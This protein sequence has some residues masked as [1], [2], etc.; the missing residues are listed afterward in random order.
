MPP[1]KPPETLFDKV[2]KFKEIITGM[3]A[4]ISALASGY[5]YVTTKFAL[6]EYVDYN[7]CYLDK[8]IQINDYTMKV[9]TL[10]AELDH[11][12]TSV[13]DWEQ[14]YNNQAVPVTEVIV[15]R[16]LNDEVAKLKSDI[17]SYQTKLSS[18]EARD[19]VK[20]L[21]HASD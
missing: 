20:E 3:V 16:K 18:Q 12:Y 2:K 19:C 7:N 4:V 6:K 9:Y 11:H 1:R 15:Y 8:R 5:T 17:S 13:A 14:K 21:K 10:S